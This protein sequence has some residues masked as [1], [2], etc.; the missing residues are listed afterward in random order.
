MNVDFKK[1]FKKFYNL[2]NFH[3][4]FSNA[5]L[6]IHRGHSAD[7]I[8]TS[9]H[10]NQTTH[11][12]THCKDSKSSAGPKSGN[13]LTLEQQ[14]RDQKQSKSKGKC[15]NAQKCKP[16]VVNMKSERQMPNTHQAKRFRAETKAAK[17]VG[18]IVGGFILCWFVIEL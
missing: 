10:N 14:N 1:P 17:T 9:D 12:S 5:P 2:E 6:R 13:A 7:E 16:V 18:I 11:L 3:K 15:G 4:I 8:K